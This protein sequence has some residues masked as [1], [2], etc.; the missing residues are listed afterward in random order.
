MLEDYT[1]GYDNDISLPV[2]EKV[3]IWEMDNEVCFPAI[4]IRKFYL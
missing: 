1:A 4:G 2:G 3:Y